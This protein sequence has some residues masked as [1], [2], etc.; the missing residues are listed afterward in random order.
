[1]EAE[2][3][4]YLE[5]HLEDLR[6]ALIRILII[7]GLGFISTVAFYSSILHLLTNHW[8]I[9]QPLLILGPLDGVFLTCKICF[10]V[11]ILATSPLW[12][13]VALH[14]ILP[15]LK[16]RE[17]ALLFPFVLGSVLFV[18]LGLSVAHKWTIPLANTYLMAF[19]GTIGQNLWTLSN[20]LD[21]ILTIYLGHALAFELGLVLFLLIHFRLLS[22]S[23]LIAKR[24]FIILFAFLLGAILTPP[25]IPTQLL[26]AGCFIICYELGI[27]YAKGLNSIYDFD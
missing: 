3:Q 27:L 26:M 10:W 1:M 23:W 12:G 20:Y 17:K 14:F 19:N 5:D 16:K 15:G 13:W 21:Y 25:D 22:A 9:D 7:V 11:S 4:V 8:L 2:E 6:S 24:R 18:C